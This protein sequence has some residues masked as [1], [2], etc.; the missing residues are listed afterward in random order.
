MKPKQNIPL[1]TAPWDAKAFDDGKMHNLTI[2][3]SFHNSSKT[4]SF[5]H[6]FTLNPPTMSSAVNHG[7]LGNLAAKIVLGV[8]W[9]TAT[10]VAFG[11][12]LGFIVI[13]L[14]VIRTSSIHTVRIRSSGNKYFR[15]LKNLA[16]DDVVYFLF[17]GSSLYLAVGPLAFGYFLDS[18]IGTLFA[19][20]LFADGVL[21]PADTVYMYCVI[22]LF[23]YVYGAFFLLYTKTL[24][25]GLLT[26]AGFGLLILLQCL[27]CFELYLTY[28]ILAL[29]SPI[30]LGRV[31]FMLCC[32]RCHEK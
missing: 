28:G 18:S 22:F 11:I 12:C 15:R 31:M 30:G 14:S 10:Q 26:K 32:L 5:S 4:K 3:V 7:D 9:P 20:G 19:W 13:P 25:P 6:E 27:H 16:N 24:F 1:Y 17:V 8:E 2:L 21:L 29:F 23:P